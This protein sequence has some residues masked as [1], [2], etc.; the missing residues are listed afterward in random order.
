MWELD[1]KEGWASENWC[2]WIMMLEKTLESP[3]ESK[4]IQPVHPKG[5]QSWLFTGR[6]DAEAETPILWSPDVKNWLIWKDPD[7]GKDWGQEE[8]GATEDEMVGWHHRLNG[9]DFE[10]SP[11]VGDGQ[12]KLVC[13][14]PW[15]TKSRTWLRNWTTTTPSSVLTWRIPWR[16][17]PGG[18]Q[19]MGSQRVGHDWMTELNW[20]KIYTHT[21][22]YTKTSL[23]VQTV[24]HLPT[25][26]ETRVQ[27]LGWENL[28][29]KEMA[30]HSSIFAWK[31]LWM[32]ELVGYSPWGHKESDTTERLTHI[33]CTAWWLKNLKA[34]F[35][36]YLS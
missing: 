25:T 6:T 13:C 31:I 10:Q 14:C 27:S 19:P 3:L 21:Y 18:L 33:R 12:G 11:R 4:E 20:N 29:E 7:A 8:K 1:H 23:V 28:L 34:I 9:L 32:E 26:W 24:E 15:I 2:F 22:K 30:T 35:H 5:N 36:L 16:E 17:E